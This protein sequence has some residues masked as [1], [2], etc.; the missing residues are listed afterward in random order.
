MMSK[1]DKP[2]LVEC[3]NRIK[4][5][6]VQLN[7][8]LKC[9][10]QHTE[11]RV[12]LL[13]DI[14]DF[15]KRKAEIDN[16]YARKVEVLSEKYL[17]KQRGLYALKKEQPDLEL[18]SPVKCWFQM[19][20]HCQRGGKD[21]TVLSTI[22]LTHLVPHLQIISEDIVRLHKRTHEISINC[23]ETLMKDM[24]KLYQSMQTY[25]QYFTECV[26]AENK[27][28]QVEKQFDKRADK[29]TESPKLDPKAKRSS[30][31]R[32]LEKLKEKR[33]QKF[34][35]NK[36]KSIK[37][38]NEYLM[39]L[40]VTNTAIDKYY[41][42]DLAAVLDAKSTGY[43][44]SLKRAWMAHDKME[45]LATEAK[46]QSLLA[47]R[48]TVDELN[49]NADKTRFLEFNSNQ[50]SSPPEFLFCPHDGDQVNQVTL[51]QSQLQRE[52]DKRYQDIERTVKQMLVDDDEMRKTLAATVQSMAEQ[53]D[54]LKHEL[55][56]AFIPDSTRVGGGPSSPTYPHPIEP[57]LNKETARVRTKLEDQ[58]VF[59]LQKFEDFLE[60]SGQLKKL[61]IKRDLLNQ[62]LGEGGGTGIDGG[63]TLSRFRLPKQPNKQ[64]KKGMTGKRNSRLNMASVKAV[65]SHF[66][67]D[68]E[69]YLKE[70]GCSIPPVVESCI[71][72]IN[73]YGM[74]H[75]GIFR[76]PGSHQDISE[77]KT[78][79]DKGEDPVSEMED[80][81]DINSV[82]GLLKLY[83]RQLDGKLFPSY[84]VDDLLQS[85][86]IQDSEKRVESIRRTLLNVPESVLVVMRYLFAFL[87]HLS[88]HNDENMMDAY[89]LAVCFGPTLLQVPES[90]DQ[91]SCQANVNEIIKTIILYHEDIF[92]DSLD[93]PKYEKLMASEE[94]VA[95]DSAS[96]V[97]VDQSAAHD[98]DDKEEQHSASVVSSVSDDESEPLYEAIA[99]YEYKG[100]STRE[101]S[102]RKGD[103]LT[104]YRR[105]SE[106][107]WEG[108]FNGKDGLIPHTYITVQEIDDFSDILSSRAES[109]LSLDSSG[110][111]QS[112]HRSDPFFIQAKRRASSENLNS[113]SDASRMAMKTKSLDRHSNVQEYLQKHKQKPSKKS[114]GA[115]ETTGLSASSSF[116]ESGVS[117]IDESPTAGSEASRMSV[118]E[119]VAMFKRST[120]NSAGIDPGTIQPRGYGTLPRIR[121]ESGKKSDIESTMKSALDDLQA[122]ELKNPSHHKDTPDVVRDTLEARGAGRVPTRKGG[123]VRGERLI[124]INT[125]AELKKITS[126]ANNN[127]NNSIENEG[128][129]SPFAVA[130]S[131]PSQSVNARS[132]MKVGVMK[133]GQRK[134]SV[135]F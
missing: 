27:L 31:F 9:L 126:G 88:Q 35:E 42:T 80:E 25:Q 59:Y 92:P 129:Y 17:S 104:L 62:A 71:R 72:V 95:D 131:L 135:K 48:K 124:G 29:S 19:L 13:N 7:E 41:N 128:R 68:M 83:F 85:V 78:Q 106:D 26:Q 74:H 24:R 118:A 6:R 119:R 77:M 97:T 34:S 50:F 114:R 121:L 94:F 132:A 67:S 54:S 109:E 15:L 21:H 117:S 73:L 64:G 5:I 43:H 56:S 99:R 98:E 44:A 89:N 63:N 101:L 111:P 112:P 93:G 122:I 49:S 33:S 86:N 53:A 16:E 18:Q 1:K 51:S 65:K 134:N 14:Q 90:Y 61:K 116:K 100:R 105:A 82:A 3:D 70:T 120:S 79:F 45:T 102:F 84:V 4:E 107:W 103:I 91:V 36:L 8:Q 40:E 22:Y 58:E 96:S 12:A 47:L 127:N 115:S 110:T 123:S 32:K 37:A 20:E 55:E 81:I 60:K 108:N 69:T 38:R 52:A 66:T 23:Q 10:D 87:N 46:A 130:Q 75:Q 76:V 30:S 39:Q 2:P 57:F 28:K 113:H 125:A 11:S 133:Q